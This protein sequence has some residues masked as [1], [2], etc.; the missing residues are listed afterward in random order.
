[1]PLLLH[2]KAW[3]ACIPLLTR[4]FIFAAGVT[5]AGCCS[6]RPFL[7]AVWFEWTCSFSFL[8]SMLSYYCRH[9]RSWLLHATS[10]SCG[11]VICVNVLL[12]VEN[13]IW[14]LLPHT[15][16]LFIFLL[17]RVK[18]AA[19]RH[20]CHCGSFFCWHDWSWLLQGTH[21]IV[22]HFSAGTIEVGCYKARMSLW[23]TALCDNL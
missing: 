11:S 10:F 19:T 13:C 18:L 3:L 15:Q 20:A 23:S 2:C 8:S 22:V 5:E 14:Y 21:V 16:P 9:G 7:V 1:M 6:P 12:F 17:A 4:R